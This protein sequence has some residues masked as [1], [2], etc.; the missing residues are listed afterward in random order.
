[1]LIKRET[2]S[3]SSKST[4]TPARVLQGRSLELHSIKGHT[5]TTKAPLQEAAQMPR[6]H[7]AMC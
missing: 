4:S 5:H 3:S 6:V 1:M 7:S 2:M